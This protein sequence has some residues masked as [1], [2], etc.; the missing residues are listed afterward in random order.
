MEVLSVLFALV[1][2]SILGIGLSA[3]GLRAFLA[4][5]PSKQLPQEVT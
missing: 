4:M 2:S 1:L 3:L 5:V